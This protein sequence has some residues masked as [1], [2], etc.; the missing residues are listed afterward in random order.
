[1]RGL[2][3]RRSLLFNVSSALSTR[4]CVDVVPRKL[5]PKT[6]HC[7]IPDKKALALATCG[8]NLRNT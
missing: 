8:A 3:K 2:S 1:M 6:N 7:L 4:E 5:R